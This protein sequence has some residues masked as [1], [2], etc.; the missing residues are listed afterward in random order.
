MSNEELLSAGLPGCDGWTLVGGQ[1]FFCTGNIH[2]HVEHKQRGKRRED[3]RTP[4]EGT[5]EEHALN[6]S[7]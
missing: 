7:V 5:E 3:I 6:I 2:Q 1:H 4:E